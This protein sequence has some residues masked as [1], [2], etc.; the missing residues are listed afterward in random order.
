MKR[1]TTR[2]NFISQNFGTAR[3]SSVP[4]SWNTGLR[5]E[6]LIPSAVRT[7]ASSK[8]GT[9]MNEQ[10]RTIFY[11]IQMAVLASIVPVAVAQEVFIPDPGLNA[12]IREALQKP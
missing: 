11:I 6:A 2:L 9:S 3:Q 4:A 7:A 10:L 1:T 5:D 8:P 12:A